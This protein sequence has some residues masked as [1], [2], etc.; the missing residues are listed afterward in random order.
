MDYPK[1]V[2]MNRSRSPRIG[3]PIRRAAT[4]LAGLTTLLLAVSTGA[5]AAFARIMPPS[6]GS[7]A[8]AGQAPVQ[9]IVIGGMPGWQVTLIAVAAAVF[10]AT[11]AVLLDRALA[12]RRHLTAPSA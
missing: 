8:T 11:G 1:E 12:A 6:D 3:R 5:P 10:A 4:I 7:G 9:T 2:T